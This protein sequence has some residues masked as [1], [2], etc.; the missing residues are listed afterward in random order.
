[1]EF[2]SFV[3]HLVRRSG[4]QPEIGVVCPPPVPVDFVYIKYGES[5]GKK[6]VFVFFP[7]KYDKVKLKFRKGF[8][9][10]YRLKD[11]ITSRTVDVHL[12]SGEPECAVE[13]SEWRLAVL[14]E[15]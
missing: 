11:L 1:M 12:N 14:V 9:Q 7:E 6:L 5:N 2:E 4:C 13:T 8:F 3:E 15:E 10:S